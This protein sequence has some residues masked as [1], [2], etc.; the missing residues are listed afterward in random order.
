[1]SGNIRGRKNWTRSLTVAVIIAI[2]AVVIGCM[3]KGK[4]NK[5]DRLYFKNTAGAVLFDHGAHGQLADSCVTCHHNIKTEN[6][7]GSCRECHPGVQASE[8]KTLA[9]ITCH[10]DSYTS[11]MMEHEEYLEIEDHSC[12]GCHTPISVSSAYHKNCSDCHLKNS[13]EKFT[14]A[15]GELLCAACHL[16]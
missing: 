9:C 3:V 6:E 4:T 13:P 15:N 1:M 2:C 8:T 11:D 16:R 12:L 5:T 14:T 7:A 10:D